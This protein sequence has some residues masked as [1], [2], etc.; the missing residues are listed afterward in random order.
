MFEKFG[1]IGSVYI[2]KLDD[3]KLLDQGC[4]NFIKPESAV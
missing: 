4:V 3:G 1:E 2:K